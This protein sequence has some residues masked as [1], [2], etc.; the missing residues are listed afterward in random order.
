MNTDK[1]ELLSA[2]VDGE[3]ADPE[4]LAE[5]LA[6]PGAIDDLLDFLRLRARL[7]QHDETLSEGFQDTIRRSLGERRSR[8]PVW[9]RYAAAIAALIAGAY[10]IPHLGIPRQP[11]EVPAGPPTPSIVLQFESGVDWHSA[12]TRING[13]E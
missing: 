1:R 4:E 11:Q 7:E 6:L 3:P 12:G 9:G 5:V 8:I 2:L 10:A 13:G